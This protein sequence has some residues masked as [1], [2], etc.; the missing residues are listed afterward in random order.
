MS[1]MSLQ[2]KPEFDD[3]TSWLKGLIEWQNFATFLPE[4]KREH[5]RKIE[6][7]NA[8]VEK[9]KAALYDKWLEIYS[10]AI[11]QDAIT[12]L[13][14][15]ELNALA[16]EIHKKLTCTCAETQITVSS[17]YDQGKKQLII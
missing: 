15:A 17:F 14:R 11:W 6:S 3:W 16:E 13:K 10:N 5:I 2:S 8:S 12:A 4:I 9:R 7:E 1:I